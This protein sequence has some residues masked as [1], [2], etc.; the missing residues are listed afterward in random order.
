MALDV[1]EEQDQY[2]YYQTMMQAEQGRRNAQPGHTTLDPRTVS[3]TTASNIRQEW[4]GHLTTSPIPTYPIRHQ[5]ISTGQPLHPPIVPS[6]PYPAFQPGISGQMLRPEEPDR[7]SRAVSSGSRSPSPNPSELHNFGYLLADGKTWRCAHPGCTSQATFTRGC[8]LRKHFKRHTK[9]LFCRYENCAQ[10]W[11][12]GFSSK[13]DRDRHENK[14]KPSVV[15]EWPDCD[16]IFSRVDNM[17]DHVKRIHR[18]TS[19]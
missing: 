17:K 15:C 7:T 10:S 19:R 6:S 2:L 9:F 18:G 5:T 16:K 3:M 13:K 4:P 12:N 11:E 8:D 14:H 1:D